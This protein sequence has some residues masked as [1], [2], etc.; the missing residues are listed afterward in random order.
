MKFGE[1]NRT[2]RLGI[3]GFGW[4]GSDQTETLLAM[5]DVEICAIC[6][7]DPERV[8]N[9]LEL[10][11]KTRGSECFGTGDYREVN[12]MADLDGVVIMTDWSTHTRIAVDAL[13]CGKAVAMEV[14]PASSVQECWDLVH[15]VEDTNGTFMFL[16]NQCYEDRTLTLL[17]MIRAGAFGQLVYA[18]GGYQHDL[19]D[20]IGNGDTYGHYRQRN[21]LHRNGEIYPTHELGLLAKAVGINRGNRMVSLTAMAS[22]AVGLHEWF[23]KNR[24]D[25]PDLA[26]VGVAQGDIAAVLIKCANGELIQLVHDCTTPHPF[27]QDLRIQGTRGIWR[28]AGGTIYIEGE[29][30]FEQWQPEEEQFKKY[31]HPMWQAYEKFGL[32]GGHDGLDYLT[33]RAFVDVVQNGGKS[34]IDVYDAAAWMSIGCLSEDSVAMGGC[35]VPIPDFTSGRW[36]NREVDV[37]S[38]YSLEDIYPDEFEDLK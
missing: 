21:F 17:N 18:S 34:P 8:K 4:R 5:P 27:N 24:P 14:G 30:P 1:I 37:P 3:I 2:V 31:R 28:E 38:W 12:R 15:A 10:V 26:S 32:R 11:K 36:L 33:L 23:V 16:E 7:T 20:E 25:R 13:R 19:R 6:D 35:P 29:S 9:G 22:K